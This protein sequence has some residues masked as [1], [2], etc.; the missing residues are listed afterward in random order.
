[1][2]GNPLRAG[3]VLS[4]VI[5][6]RNEG[7]RLERCLQSVQ[8]MTL[9]GIRLEVVYV[10]SD[11]VDQS[12]ATAKSAEAEVV[13]LHST[14]PTAARGRNAGA[15]R[16]SGEFILFLDGDTILHPLFPA[17]ALE[18]FVDPS[19]AVVCGQRR[20]IHPHASVFNRVVD[21]DWMGRPGLTE[22]CGGDAVM[23]RSAFE[24]AGGFDETLIAG[25]EPDLC[26]RLRERG[27]RILQLDHPMTGHDIA[28][29][30]FS[31]YWRRSLRTGYA[32]AE[33]S[34][35]YESTDLPLWK[36]A[37]RANR[38]RAWFLTAGT[39]LVVG[40][41]LFFG[42]LWPLALA[43]LAGIGLVVRTAEKNRWKSSDLVTRLLYGLHSHVQQLPIY[44]GQLQYSQDRRRDRRRG[45][46]EYKA[47]R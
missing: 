33:V 27:W 22:F 12:V 20:E 9:P 41:S 7:E 2:S 30:S 4:V 8:S 11:S 14:H 35:R 13:V 18:Q 26:R 31:Q 6:G 1:M 46:I 3:S 37:A 21:L 32:Y 15:A 24:Q 45:L 43:G 28:M 40:A 38:N 47:A 16:C 39:C 29:H 36:N 34:R 25:E 44:L 42:T 10:D 17:A 5:I 23:R 19:I